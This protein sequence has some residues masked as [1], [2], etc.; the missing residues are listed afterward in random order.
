ML[1]QI[2]NTNIN[3]VGDFWS[4]GRIFRSQVVHGS[5]F[6]ALF[7]PTMFSIQFFGSIVKTMVWTRSSRSFAKPSGRR[8]NPEM[9]TIPQRLKG[10][11]NF[12]KK[13][14]LFGEYFGA[15]GIGAV[16]FVFVGF[17]LPK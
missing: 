14:S 5:L 4:N 11:M 9:L 2:S 17:A 1:R 15:L 6:G 3:K 12:M 10:R 7:Y 16:T 13:E 8:P